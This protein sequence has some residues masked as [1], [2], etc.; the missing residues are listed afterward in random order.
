MLRPPPLSWLR[1]LPLGLQLSS[2][3]QGSSRSPP[4]H[5][6]R[7]H[8]DPLPNVRRPSG[9]VAIRRRRVPPAFSSNRMRAR[10]LTKNLAPSAYSRTGA[11]LLR[12]CHRP[13]TVGT[14]RVSHPLRA[15][16]APRAF[17]G[18]FHPGPAL[19]VFTLQGLHPLQS[20]DASRR[21]RALL[22]FTRSRP[23][24]TV[25]PPRDNERRASGHPRVAAR[26]AKRRG[27]RP[28]SARAPLA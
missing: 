16:T 27:R 15:L 28:G 9:F 26:G 10:H 18:L 8:G 1:Q 22:T 24:P 11:N 20:R 21:P 3:P 4:V 23:R 7:K 2:G 12:T 14:S 17:P 6:A 5:A 13:A 25:H 19:G